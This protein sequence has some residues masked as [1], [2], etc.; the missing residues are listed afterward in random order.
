MIP[1]NGTNAP[2]L[3]INL[4]QNN[5]NAR[6]I[7]NVSVL[8]HARQTDALNIQMIPYNAPNTP[9]LQIQCIQN[10]V[11]NNRNAWTIHNMS[12]LPHARRTDA[13]NTP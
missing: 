6:T 8:P 2:A 7:H 9:A 13:L 5:R 4:V 3:Q 10:L 12:V 11:Q 1:Y